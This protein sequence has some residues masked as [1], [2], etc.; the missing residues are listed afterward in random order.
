M[1]KYNDVLT[2]TCT[3]MHTPPQETL[4]YKTGTSTDQKRET[5]EQK[6]VH[7]IL[8]KICKKK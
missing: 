3:H 2:H 8:H 4:F 5:P 1:A 6:K 7:H